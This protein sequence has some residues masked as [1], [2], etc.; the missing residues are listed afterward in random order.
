MSGQV[1]SP[2]KRWRELVIPERHAAVLAGQTL[3]RAAC[4]LIQAATYR[5]VGTLMQ[6]LVH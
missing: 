5:V 3:E 1:V 6:A 2:D 4:G